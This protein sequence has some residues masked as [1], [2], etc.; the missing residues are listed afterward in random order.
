MTSIEPAEAIER[1]PELELLG[2]A[3]T[4]RLRPT[5]RVQ[6]W[7]TYASFAVQVGLFIYDDGSASVISM[8][9]GQFSTQ[10]SGGLRRM[11][12]HALDLIDR[13]VRP[14]C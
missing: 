14:P 11:V 6:M 10:H 4:W 13:P 12:S 7:G 8:E 2:D 3:W 9:W 1:F 5:S